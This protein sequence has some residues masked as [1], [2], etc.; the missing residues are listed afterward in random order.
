MTVVSKKEFATHQ[1][2]YFDLAIKERVYIKKDNYMFFV[3][4]ADEDEELDEIIEYQKAKSHKS[5]AI[6]FDAAFA[7]I[8]AFIN[9]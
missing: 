7:E 4:N 3:T 8:E 9:Q 5:D 2:K 1:D 6:P